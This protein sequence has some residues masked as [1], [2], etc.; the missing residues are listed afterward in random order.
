[1]PPH[2]LITLWL[3]LFVTLLAPTTAQMPASDDTSEDASDGT[4]LDGSFEE[5]ITIPT[6]GQ[7]CTE[8]KLICAEGRCF[9]DPEYAKKKKEEDV[10]WLEVSRV[11]K[12]PELPAAGTFTVNAIETATCDEPSNISHYPRSNCLDPYTLPIDF[13]VQPNCHVPEE[14]VV[15]T[16]TSLT[17]KGIKSPDGLRP[18]ISGNRVSRILKG[19]LG[20][21]IYVEG[22]DFVNGFVEGIPLYVNKDNPVDGFFKQHG[23]HIITNGYLSMKDC[24]FS[25]GYS[26]ERYA[27][28]I[29][30][31]TG[32]T[33][34]MYRQS[35][36]P[37]RGIP[38]QS[39]AMTVAS[40]V[41]LQPAST[42]DIFNNHL[43]EGLECKTSEWQC[44]GNT[45]VDHSCC[46][47]LVNID[48]RDEDQDYPVDGVC[49]AR[50]LQLEE[51][52]ADS[53]CRDLLLCQPGPNLRECVCNPETRCASKNPDGNGVCCSVKDMD[54]NGDCCA[55]ECLE[56][57]DTAS[58]VVYFFKP[59]PSIN[60]V[61]IKKGRPMW[62]PVKNVCTK[63]LTDGKRC[64]IDE[65]C[66]VC[67]QDGDG[68]DCTVSRS[69]PVECPDT[70]QCNEA[71][72]KSC[73]S[74]TGMCKWWGG[75]VVVVVVGAIGVVGCCSD[76]V[77]LFVCVCLLLQCTG[78]GHT[79]GYCSFG[80]GVNNK[81]EKMSAENE[82][83]GLQSYEEYEYTAGDKS[84]E[85][86]Q[87]V[88]EL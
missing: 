16:D 27:S 57:K 19:E 75:V 40:A 46:A 59:V 39:N 54:S 71:W 25:G 67:T 87:G 65:E 1:M 45:G 84:Y 80:S 42:F 5:K 36:R 10:D 15:A 72:M 68:L 22:L 3:L 50:M 60:G 85:F 4:V 41:M 64:L 6:T 58:G 53:C 73:K 12:P 52:P 62:D 11:C 8:C 13:G 7:W 77:V 32:A 17:I 51:L 74:R 86:K 82:G 2:H 20:S 43:Y 88:Q 28:G 49:C 23:A 38:S 35:W 83:L 34:Y 81:K 14:V 56:W 61:C 9:V 30:H 69:Q 47:N 76:G 33:G 79:P 21:K 31:L 37:P 29:Y 66:Q 78:D 26:A 48:V 24:V 70:V 18:I 44:K 63:K 55:R